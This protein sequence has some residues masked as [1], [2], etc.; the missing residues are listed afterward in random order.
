M[1]I[2]LSYFY[3]KTKRKLIFMKQSDL[4]L[5]GYLIKLTSYAK[6]ILVIVS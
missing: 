2:T 1:H 4:F 3:L 6:I 5:L